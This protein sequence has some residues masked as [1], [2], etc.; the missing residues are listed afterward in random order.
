MFLILLLV[1]TVIVLYFKVKD[2]LEKAIGI[3]A[4]DITFLV[5]GIISLILVIVTYF[6][7]KFSSQVK[8][9]NNNR[10]FE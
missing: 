3:T 9:T 7:S 5:G 2:N 10:Q 4:S 8:N 1:I 6:Y